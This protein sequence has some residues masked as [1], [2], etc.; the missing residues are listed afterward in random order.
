V[1]SINLLALVMEM[2]LVFHEVEIES[3]YVFHEVEIESL[4]II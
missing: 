2:V 4:N 3:A 1:S